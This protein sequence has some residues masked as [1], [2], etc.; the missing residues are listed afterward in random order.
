M[1]KSVINTDESEGKVVRLNLMVVFAYL[2]FL[3]ASMLAIVYLSGA[4]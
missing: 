1:V 4:Y 3:I 2:F